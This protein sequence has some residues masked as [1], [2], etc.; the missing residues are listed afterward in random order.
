MHVF[1]NLAISGGVVVNR[2]VQGMSRG[3]RSRMVYVLLKISLAFS[4]QVT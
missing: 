2:D 4:S 3:K 1:K